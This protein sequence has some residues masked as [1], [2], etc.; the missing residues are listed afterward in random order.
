[1]KPLSLGLRQRVLKACDG[2]D[3]TPDQVAPRLY[4]SVGMVKKLLSQ[5]QR[6]GDIRSQ[7]HRCGWSFSASPR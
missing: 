2:Q 5:R 6:L 7:H 1:M 3:S 4:D